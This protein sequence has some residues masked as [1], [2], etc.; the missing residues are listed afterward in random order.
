MPKVFFIADT[1]FGQKNIIA[2][3]NRPFATVEEMDKELIRLWN[4]T[5]QKDDTVFLLGDFSFYNKERSAEIC[6]QLQGNKL[7]V[8]GNHDRHPLQWYRDCGFQEVYNYPIIYA[9]F[10]MLSHKPLYI[11]QNM[12]YG[13]IFGHVHGNP[14]YADA[15]SNSC[16]VSLER[17]GYRPLEFDEVKRRMGLTE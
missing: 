13:N 5:V 11:N 2:Y 4:E 9:K 15:S 1:H 6:R 7:L 10:W 16:C 3:E 14:A 8:L 12:P 17:T